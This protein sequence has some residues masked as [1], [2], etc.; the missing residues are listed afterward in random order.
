MM[1]YHDNRN[2]GEKQQKKNSLNGGI[3]FCVL[4]VS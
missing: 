1:E 3:T 4:K 2:Q